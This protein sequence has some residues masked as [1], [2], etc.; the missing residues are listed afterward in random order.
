MYLAWG[1]TAVDRDSWW[2]AGETGPR[3]AAKGSRGAAVTVRTERRSAG[4]TAAGRVIMTDLRWSNIFQMSKKK[5]NTHNCD[6]IAFPPS[7]V[8]LQK[9]PKQRV[10][11]SRF[12]S[13]ECG[14]VDVRNFGRFISIS[15]AAQKRWHRPVTAFAEVSFHHYTPSVWGFS[16]I[17]SVIFATASQSPSFLFGGLDIRL[18]FSNP[19]NL[20][21]I[22]FKKYVVTLFLCHMTCK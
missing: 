4:K 12:E 16:I 9:K 3:E 17:L 18:Q 7:D 1:L 8:M 21:L 5:K 11:S 2:R 14:G 6:M 15:T 20:I 10:F 13:F 19:S 22:F